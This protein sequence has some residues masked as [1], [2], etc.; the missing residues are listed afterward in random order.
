MSSW[1]QAQPS[2]RSESTDGVHT[3]TSCVLQHSGCVHSKSAPAACCE[4]LLASM[5]M[6]Q[7]AESGLI[8]SCLGIGAAACNQ[9]HTHVYCSAHTA[10]SNAGL[11][12]DHFS[13][14]HTHIFCYQSHVAQHSC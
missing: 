5:P 10:A 11:L 14:R 2:V 3:S 12:G 13:L 9:G 7:V 6:Q 8:L 1:L 4:D